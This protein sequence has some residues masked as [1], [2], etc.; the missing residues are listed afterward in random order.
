MTHFCL[1]SDQPI[2]NLLP[3]LQPEMRPDRVV[4]AVSDRMREKAAWLKREIEKRSIPVEELPLPNVYD[5]PDLQECFMNWLAAHEDADVALNI[6]GGTK[7]MAIAAQEAFRAADKPVFYVNIETDELSWLGRDRAQVRLTHQATLKTFLGVHGIALESGLSRSGLSPEWQTFSQE[8]A[9]VKAVPW[10]NALGKL[11]YEAM[12]AERRDVLDVGRIL[13]E[14]C[15]CWDD[16]LESLFYNEI[17]C[18]RTRLSFRSAEARRFANGGWL[19]HLVFEAVKGL[20]GVHEAVLNACVRDAHGNSNEFDVA[21]LSRNRLF[22]IECKTK[23]FD[24][25]SSDNGPA[26]E[27][28]YKLEALRKAGGL[29]TRCVLVSFRPVADAHKRRAQDAGVTVIDQNGLP[30]LKECLQSALK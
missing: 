27:A 19:E 8:L 3:L 30:R 22:I 28:I 10:E 18:D 2:P 24:R 21:L 4:L 16:L 29:R 15:P 26:A 11:N 9:F 25:A 5:I 23:K 14:G 12:D 20:D 13:S 7:P 17:I 1:V 6:T